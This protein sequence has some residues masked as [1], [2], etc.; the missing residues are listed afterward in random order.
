MPRKS[1]IPPPTDQEI[2]ALANVPPELAAR[3]IG[4]SAPTLYRA[5]QENRAPFGFA[6]EC[7]GSWAYNISPGLLMKYRSGDLPTYRLK[8]VEQL[9]V[10]GVERALDLRL[11]ALSRVIEGVQL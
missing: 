5:L 1:T 4:W 8:E 6:V 11:S 3:Y 10:E 2:A 9:A 7:P